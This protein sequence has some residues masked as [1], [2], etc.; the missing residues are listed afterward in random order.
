ME[1]IKAVVFLAGSE[2]YA[3]PIENVIS[4]DKPG[5][6]T[7]VPHMPDHFLGMTTVREEVIPLV[8]AQKAL[9]PVFDGTG[10]TKWIVIQIDGF[11]A[12]LAV[13]DAREII[14]V[15]A[16]QLK[17]SGLAAY[18]GTHFIRGIVYIEKGRLIPVIDPQEFI[19]SLEGIKALKEYIEQNT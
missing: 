15:Q 8:D 6:V 16:D 14:E 2:E 3:I 1:S 7:P 5:P 13:K 11:K 18:P 12:G 4:I 10:E 19:G 9:Y 17:Q